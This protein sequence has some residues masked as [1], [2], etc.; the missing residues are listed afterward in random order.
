MKVDPIIFILQEFCNGIHKT[1]NA[2]FLDL[3]KPYSDA[4]LAPSDASL[5]L[6]YWGWLLGL[7]EMGSTLVCSANF[8]AYRAKSQGQGTYAKCASKGAKSASVYGM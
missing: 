4:L 5:A 8:S 6:L 3:F 1:F 2:K 7:A